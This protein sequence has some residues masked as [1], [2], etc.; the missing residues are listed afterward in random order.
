MLRQ[1]T[2]VGHWF[3]LMRKASCRGPIKS[4][5]TENQEIFSCANCDQLCVWEMREGYISISDGPRCVPPKDD[6]DYDF[7]P[8]PL[9][10]LPP[11][12]PEIFVHYLEHKNDPVSDIHRLVWTSRLPKRKAKR[13]IDCDIGT[14]GWG[15]YI[16]E[17]PNRTFVFC[18]VV[19]SVLCS[20][21]ISV[22]WAGLKGDVQGATGLGT[23]VLGV[24]S[25]I[26]AA[27]MFKFGE[28]V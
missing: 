11:V 16:K 26:M 17:G 18:M 19:L 6:S 13:L 12:P 24:H 10:P 3:C 2:V 28:L 27:F 9:A 1:S 25:V 15:I 5:H 22:I 4:S 20:V 23:L 8:R 14:Y 7:V 21:L